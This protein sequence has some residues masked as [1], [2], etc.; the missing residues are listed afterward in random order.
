MPGL[1]RSYPQERIG[2][3]QV[4]KL[5]KARTNGLVTPKAPVPV[6]TKEK[7]QEKEA[8]TDSDPIV[9]SDTA[10]ESGA[11]DGNSWPDDEDENEVE[12]EVVSAGARNITSME[13]D[14]VP[15]RDLGE[16]MSARSR[17]SHAKQKV[18]AQERKASK[19]HAESIARSK[20][21]WERL[22]RKSHVPKPERKELV[23]E[24]FAI[25]TGHVKDFV[26]KHDSVRVIQTALKYANPEQR[27][28]IVGELKGSY[29]E[30]AESKYAKFLIGK[31]LV[32]D[33]R[34]EFRDLVVPEF[35]GHVRRLIKHPEAA[36][37]LDDIYRGAATSEQKGL[38]LSEWYGAEFAL[39][40]AQ[41]GQSPGEDVSDL[42]YYLKS[43]QEK[44]GPI[45]RSLHDLINS[46]VQR[47]MTG[48][49]ML[50]DAMLQYYLNIQPASSEATEFIELLKSDIDDGGDLLKNLA[51]TPSGARV[52][53]LA[54]AYG[55]A[56]DRKQILR[57]YKGMIPMLAYDAYGHQILLAAYELID[58]TV[59][60]SKSVFPELL[61]T[62]TPTPSVS[63]SKE[64]KNVQIQR[65]DDFLAFCIHPIGRIPLLY[66]FHPSPSIPP[67]PGDPE[68]QYVQNEKSEE[69]HHPLLFSSTVPFLK[70]ILQ[71]RG[72]TSKKD[73]SLRRHE[74]LRVVTLPLLHLIAS[75]ASNL[76]TSTNGCQLIKDV[77]LSPLVVTDPDAEGDE[78]GNTIEGVEK[79]REKAFRAIAAFLNPSSSDDIGGDQ[80]RVGLEVQEPLIGPDTPVPAAGRMLKA[81]IQGRQYRYRDKGTSEDQDQKPNGL[82]RTKSNGNERV[83][84]HGLFYEAITSSS[85]TSTSTPV[86][87]MNSESKSV[88]S[89]PVLQW[90]IGPNSFCIVALL[91]RK[92]F[93]ARDKVREVLGGKEG[94]EALK[95][96]AST[97]AIASSNTDGSGGRSKRKKGEA[98]QKGNKGAEIL[99]EM[100]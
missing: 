60:M 90:A 3:G 21:L 19:P 71:I 39:F 32:V 22:R 13:A 63:S 95:K 5:K 87:K 2:V 78:G 49:T 50:H 81:L 61:G 55:T 57:V 88:T 34:G 67:T 75:R 94:K 15:P 64:Q 38:L 8:E 86:P 76:V 35:Y 79:G 29:K 20:K 54:L 26:F 18:L 83:E 65:E 37:I 80:G 23:A 33:K 52:V 43:H 7:E 62:V 9:E 72:T 58:D 84:F 14:I 51:F 6:P 53:C 12:E 69:S 16:M 96:A 70:T 98:K 89:S 11:D 56:K 44:R 91:E 74:L 85:P 99:L 82:T 68:H 59:L 42:K 41:P 36:W 27:K 4:K 47:K 1:K 92:D 48:F 66:L 77:L 31:I 97:S 28:M 46:L 93:A 17:E 25:I 10:S 45:I 24:L 73:P 30:L 100:L 40:K